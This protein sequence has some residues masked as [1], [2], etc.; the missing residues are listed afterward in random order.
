MS[1][2]IDLDS[3]QRDREAFPNPCR[4][5]L[6]VNQV[7]TWVRSTREVR[8]LPQN[9]NERPLDFVSSLN[10]VSAVIPYPRIELYAN[11]SI[12]VD[13][14]T[15]NTFT[16]LADHGLASG[17][18]VMTSSPGFTTKAGLSR[19]VEYHVIVASPTTFQVELAPG[20]GVITL[21]V[22]TGLNMS[23]AVI[24]DPTAIDSDYLYVK[25]SLND[26]I[27]ITMVPR[28]Y[29]DI[30]CMKYNDTR[31]LKTIGGILADAKFVLIP[32][33]TQHDDTGTPTWIHL[34]SMGEQ[35]VRF[36]RDDPLSI[37]FVTRSGKTIDVFTEPD[38]TIPT[39]PLKQTMITINV[40]PYLRDALYSNHAIE[41]IPQ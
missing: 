4:Y 39:N 3:I 22:A 1:T 9:A 20:S 40:T 36:K 41:P 21:P 35:V 25:D 12:V 28:I 34:K 16:S 11:R 37:D 6:T 14:I 19:N 29:L 24:D 26:A 18:I 10:I 15:A 8:A 5:T 7:D 17:D 31:C 33:R 27:A 23:L 32:D 13:S 38:L 2:Y 30:H